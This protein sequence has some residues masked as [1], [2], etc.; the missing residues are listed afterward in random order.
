MSVIAITDKGGKFSKVLDDSNDIDKVFRISGGKYRRYPNQS[1]LQSLFDLK[2]HA[3]NA[4]DSLRTVKG[5]SQ[6]HKVIKQTKP[7]A[8]FIKGGYVSVPVGLAAKVASVPYITH[9]SDAVPSLSTKIIGKN[10][11]KRLSGMPIIGVN[12]QNLVH[13]GVP[14]SDK[15]NKVSASEQSKL[16]SELGIPENTKV[17][18]VTGGSQGA[19]R[20]N[21]VVEKILPQLEK[22]GFFTVHQTGKD[23]HAH[24]SE[25]YKPIT[26]IDE[27]YKYSGAADVIVS[28]AGS[29][30]AEFAQQSKPMIAIPA[31][32]LA[33]GHQISNAKI[34]EDN[35]AAIILDEDELESSPQLLADAAKEL[36]N[37]KT[38][39]AALA[40]AAQKVYPDDSAV[41]I[42][43]MLTDI[44]Q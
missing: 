5:L 25:L 11:A 13:V 24:S 40:S 30:L 22:E 20:I 15:F 14:I 28:R 17:L 6:A 3:L 35:K 10:A 1:K 21:V 12:E 27:I 36:L 34:L 44:T 42:A 8:I 2:T 4:R 39:S 31:K 19:Q 29:S 41:I 32:H 37:D 9:D 33:G 26:Y 16:K 38:K 18:L 7:S 23:Y 43:K